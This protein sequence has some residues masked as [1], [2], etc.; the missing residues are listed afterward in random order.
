MK[1]GLFAIILYI[2]ALCSSYSQNAQRT[3]NHIDEIRQTVNLYFEGMMEA[4]V[5]KLEEAFHSQA[6][7][8][9]FRA[10]S[11]YVTPFS[12]W[13]AKFSSAAQKETKS[14]QNIINSIEI[15]GSMAFVKTTLHWPSII[16][17]DYLTLIQDK[18]LW[19]IVHKS[20]HEQVPVDRE[21]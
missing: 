9:G 19:K 3:Y 15:N 7:L 13:S 17:Y 21:K 8:I 5:Q 2:G 11:L 20:W 10:D 14:H 6:Q 16:Y 4:N 18:G 1:K 12:Q